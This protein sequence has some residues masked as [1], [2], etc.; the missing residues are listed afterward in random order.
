VAEK[1]QDATHHAALD[2]VLR[3]LV[4]DARTQLLNACD[5]A[6][7]PARV[8]LAV[9]LARP[10][11]PG[12]LKVPGRAFACARGADYYYLRALRLLSGAYDIACG[13]ASAAT[14]VVGCQWG[15]AS[16]V[17]AGSERVLPA[18]TR[19]PAVAMTGQLVST[20]QSTLAAASAAPPQSASGSSASGL[21]RKRKRDD[22]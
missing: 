2:A 1:L 10:P 16:A 18:S 14:D 11:P 15:A 17:A 13:W 8:P 19:S 20:T 9:Q 6:A 4:H 12:I 3:S 5:W 7:A 22:D 21:T